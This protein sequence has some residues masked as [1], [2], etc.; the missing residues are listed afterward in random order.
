[1]WHA[2]CGNTQGTLVPMMLFC[3]CYLFFVKHAASCWGQLYT[4]LGRISSHKVARG[5]LCFPFLN[6]ASLFETS[7]WNE[8]CVDDIVILWISLSYLERSTSKRFC[9]V[10]FFWLNQATQLRIGNKFEPL[11]GGSS[12]T[13]RVFGLIGLMRGGVPFLSA[14]FFFGTNCEAVSSNL[15]MF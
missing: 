5:T 4:L 6:F 3:F 8:I 15:F 13:R 12:H 11:V 9:F 2:A 14:N 10:G 1:M 7:N